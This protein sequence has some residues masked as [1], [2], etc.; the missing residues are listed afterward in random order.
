MA[1][2]QTPP[3]SPVTHVQPAPAPVP[4]EMVGGKVLAIT[5]GEP[6]TTAVHPELAREDMV[7]HVDHF[8]LWYGPKQALFDVSMGVPRHKITALIGPSGCGKSTLLRSVNRMNDLIDTLKVKGDMRLN[9]DPIYGR[10]VDV[11]ELR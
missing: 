10:S 9:G 6:V 5:R 2:L 4:A 1:A 11:I 3:G 7:L 8:S